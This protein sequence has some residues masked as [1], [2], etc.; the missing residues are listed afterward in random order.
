MIWRMSFTYPFII[1]CTFDI[2]IW[3]SL[4]FS[5]WERI[6]EIARWISSSYQ[7]NLSSNDDDTVCIGIVF[8]GVVSFIILYSDFIAVTCFIKLFSYCVIEAD[9]D[10]TLSLSVLISKRSC[11]VMNL[12]FDFISSIA[13]LS[14]VIVSERTLFDDDV[15]DVSFDTIFAFGEDGFVISFIASWYNIT[16]FFSKFFF[17][18][19]TLGSFLHILHCNIFISSINSTTSFAK[20]Q[21]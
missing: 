12:L 13:A 7:S 19:F 8:K 9:C 3:S 2:S 18:I 4:L 17:I 14:N 10:A 6:T 5:L 1:S 16:F 21:L 20:S 15:A 11:S